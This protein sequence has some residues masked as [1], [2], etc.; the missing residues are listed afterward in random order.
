VKITRILY[1]LMLVISSF[2]LVSTI[3]YNAGLKFSVSRY[4]HVF[5]MSRLFDSGIL[6]QYLQ[7]ACAE[8]HY[9]ICRYQ[10]KFP[11]DFLWDF[12]GSPLYQNGGWEGNRDEYN[13]IIRDILSTPKYW[14][15]LIAREVEGTMKQFFTFETGDTA[16]QEEGSSTMNAIKHH[17]PE[18]V[19]EFFQSKQNG[20]RLD[21]K[22]LNLFQNYLISFLLLCSMMIYFIPGFNPKYKL[23]LTYFLIALL[24]N[25]FVCSSLVCVVD[26]FQSRVVWLLTLP[27]MLYLA[28]REYTIKP[29]KKLFSDSSRSET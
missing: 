11:W 2:L 1:A 25:A 13:A 22:M 26:R 18:N 20:Q 10:H 4:G 6:E 27:F 24:V 3:H 21:W 28:N 8:K 14:P 15:R 16:K 29:L 7:D 17:W 9:F 12:T 19:K 23:F 5:F